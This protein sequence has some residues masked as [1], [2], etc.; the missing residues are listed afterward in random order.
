L[1]RGAGF[2]VQKTPGLVGEINQDPP[3]ANIGEN[4]AA[5]I[6]RRLIDDR[7]NP[8]CSG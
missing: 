6:G 5:A 7:R 2:G 1:E 3:V 8:V 4:G